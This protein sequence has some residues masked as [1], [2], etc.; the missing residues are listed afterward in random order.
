MTLEKAPSGNSRALPAPYKNY[1]VGVVKRT[2]GT[3]KTITNSH[4]TLKPG[5]TIILQHIQNPAYG[6]SFLAF[7]SVFAAGKEI[8]CLLCDGV[9]RKRQRFQLQHH[10]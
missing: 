2:C 1:E 9:W 8:K 4:S 3:Y 10:R 6:N 5:N 7:V